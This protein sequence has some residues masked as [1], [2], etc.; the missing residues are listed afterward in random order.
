MLG[1]GLKFFFTLLVI[2]FISIIVFISKQNSIRPITPLALFDD[3]TEIVLKINKS[4]DF[5]Q[6]IEEQPSCGFIKQFFYDSISL[7]GIIPIS[8]FEKSNQ[9]LLGYHPN[10]GFTVVLTFNDNNNSTK[11]ISELKKNISKNAK[12]HEKKEFGNT[13]YQYID[14]NNHSFAFSDYNGLILINQS[15]ENCRRIIKKLAINNSD[16]AVSGNKIISVEKFSSPDAD[17][18]IFI[19]LKNENTTFPYFS[20]NGM[21]AFDLWIKTGTLL[22]NGLSSGSEAKGYM[23]TIKNTTPLNSKIEEVIPAT[24]KN[25]Y[26]ISVNK[27]LPLFQSINEQSGLNFNKSF[28]ITITEFINRIFANEIV[29]FSINNEQSIVGLKIK[30]KSVTEYNLKNMIETAS[31]QMLEATEHKYAFDKETTFPIFQSQWGDFTGIIFGKAF[32][33]E[34]SKFMT[35]ISDYLYISPDIDLLKNL[36]NASV[37]QQTMATSVEYKSIREQCASQTSM[38]LFQ[39]QGSNTDILAFW[40]SDKLHKSINNKLNSYPYKM[41]WQ[42][43]YDM[44]KPYHNIII[45]FGQQKTVASNNFEWKSRLEHSSIL[46]PT[47]VSLGQDGKSGILVQDSSHTLYMLNRQGRILWQKQL[48]GLILSEIYQTEKNN[49]KQ[50]LFNTPSTLYLTNMEGIDYERY[51]ISFRSKATT[52]IALFDYDSNKNYRLVIPHEDRT[53]SMIDIDGN[54]IDGWNFGTTDAIVTTPVQH[55]SIGTKDFI[56]LGDTLRVYILDRRGEQRIKPSELYGKAS[57]SQFYYSSLRGRWF[58]TTHNGEL[59]SVS[60]DGTVRHE[61]LFDLSNNHFYIYADFSPDGKGNHIFVDKNRL[62]VIDNQGKKIF[63]H[64]FKGDILDMPSIYRFTAKKRGIGIVDRIDKKVF[65]FNQ[66]GMQLPMFPL[67]GI[68]PFTIAKYTGENDYHLLVGHIDGFIY[69]IKIE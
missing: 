31:R 45:D 48:D 52:G 27:P 43:S 44:E 25:F 24:T 16:N 68:T 32:S 63:T 19:N 67:H 22:I 12:I 33:T 36:I 46:K 3:S 7:P 47:V 34:R 26:H 49:N 6:K 64:I 17:A 8:Y 23:S 66:N 4:S 53:I 9:L 60:L 29:K 28:G 57:N 20:D 37:L 15:F 50:L 30:G 61:K 58:T 13:I 18:N 1:R 51:P 42:I 65:L 39:Q 14:L 11:W 40:L 21:A 38:T 35:I 2:A 62:I 56:L 54:K 41:L 10:D 69:D 55:F 5:F 59:M